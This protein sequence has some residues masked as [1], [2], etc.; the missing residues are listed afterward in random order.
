MFTA[1]SGRSGPLPERAGGAGAW[2]F[3]AFRLSAGPASFRFQDP[4]P[5]IRLFFHGKSRPAFPEGNAG[6]LPLQVIR[7][8]RTL[9][10]QQVDDRQVGNER[11]FVRKGRTIEGGR[12][13]PDFFGKTSVSNG[14]RPRPVR[15]GKAGAPGRT[16]GPSGVSGRERRPPTLA[17]NPRPADLRR[18]AGRRSIGRE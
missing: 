2:V 12:P 5:P 16:G 17:G 1:K 15:N 13:A 8:L 14:I 18:T 11:E 3:C 9:A 4:C 7:G 6:P 10:E